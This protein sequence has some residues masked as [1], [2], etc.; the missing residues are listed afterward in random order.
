MCLFFSFS[1]KLNTFA[2]QS[3]SSI[4]LCN[5]FPFGPLNHTSIE[6]S[7][8][9]S[10]HGVVPC[11]ERL[12]LFLFQS[13]FLLFLPCL[14]TS[15]YSCILCFPEPVL[16]GAR[17]KTGNVLTPSEQGVEQVRNMKKRKRKKAQYHG[18]EMHKSKSHQT[19]THRGSE[20]ESTVLSLAELQ[21]TSKIN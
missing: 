18:E 8:F 20:S 13:L 4:L 7:E 17:P 15:L 2:G 10:L 11:F 1:S 19:A 6:Y 9:A 16:D 3:F 14:S 21:R 12:F 5:W